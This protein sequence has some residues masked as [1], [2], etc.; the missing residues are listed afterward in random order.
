MALAKL[1]TQGALYLFKRSR[2]LDLFK[3]VENFPHFRSKLRFAKLRPDKVK[4][5]IYRLRIR[6]NEC[7]PNSQIDF[8]MTVRITLNPD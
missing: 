1:L 7:S 4:I 5:K 3:E 8:Q 6:F 2:H